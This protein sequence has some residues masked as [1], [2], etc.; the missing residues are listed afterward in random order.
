M[1]Y[2]KYFGLA[3]WLLI[4]YH[5]ISTDKYFTH[6][7]IFLV[8][9]TYTY[10][11]LGSIHENYKI[12]GFYEYLLEYPD[13]PNYNRWKQRVNIKDTTNTQTSKDIGY[14]PIHI[15]FAPQD[16]EFGGIARS[17]KPAEAIFDGTPGVAGHWFTIG[18]LE[19]YIS[20]YQMAGFY[21]GVDYKVGVRKVKLWIRIPKEC[22]TFEY[23]FCIY[24]SN[25]VYF[26][27][28]IPLLNDS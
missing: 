28:S 17:D 27:L 15:D 10:S 7:T 16:G 13:E 25:L 6:N 26:F 19:H 11:I 21:N 4:F 1:D 8:N 5:D 3:E 23:N 22:Q 2:T 20:H 9:T 18:A 12:N 14:K 24:G